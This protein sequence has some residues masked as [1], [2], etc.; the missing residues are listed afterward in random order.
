MKEMLHLFRRQARGWLIKNDNPCIV[1]YGA[2]DLDHLSFR[3]AERFDER[4]WIDIEVER[5]LRLLGSNID[6]AIDGEEF[7]HAEFEILRNRHG[8]NETGLLID[9]PHAA[10]QR[11]AGSGQ[12]DLVA[13]A[14]VVP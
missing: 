3:G 7:L 9:H 11:F 4:E 8:R 12:R 6:L 5:L 10:L 14:D 1:A 13:T 2:R